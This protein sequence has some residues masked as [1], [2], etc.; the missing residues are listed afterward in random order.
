MGDQIRDIV[1]PLL[2]IKEILDQLKISKGD[3]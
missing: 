2:S 1:T 3:Y